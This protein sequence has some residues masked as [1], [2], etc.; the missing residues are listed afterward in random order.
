MRPEE[1]FIEQPVRSLQTMLRVIAEDN[2]RFSTVVPDGIYGPSTMQ[3]VFALQKAVGLPATGIVNQETWEAIVVLYEDALI[4]IGQGEP[5]EIIL[6]AG[7]VFRSGDSNPYIY[8]MQ[9]ILIQL[10]SE[11]LSI[12]PPD[13]TGI[14]DAP[15]QDA[16]SAFQKLAGLPETGELDKITWKHLAKQFSSYAIHQNAL[17]KKQSADWSDDSKLF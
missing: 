8:L 6:D 12:Q 2:P 14:L 5:I 1:S 13:H 15:S 4:R 16:L 7:Q 11:H 10:S 3:A 9:S 17:I